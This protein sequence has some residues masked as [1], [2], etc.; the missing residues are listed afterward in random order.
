MAFRRY[1]VPIVLAAFI[2]MATVGCLGKFQ[3]T[4]KVYK[5]KSMNVA[6]E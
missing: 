2:P 3:L 5:Y 6:I 1:V 4:K